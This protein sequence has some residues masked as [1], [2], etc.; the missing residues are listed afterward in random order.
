MSF[1]NVIIIISEPTV[2]DMQ[3]YWHWGEKEERLRE[4]GKWEGLTMME[5][6]GPGRER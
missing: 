2:G 5:G 1:T 6:V 4:V 3:G